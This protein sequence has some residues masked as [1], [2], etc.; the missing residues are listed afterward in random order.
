M[1]SNIAL[2]NKYD[3]SQNKLTYCQF[4]VALFAVIVYFSLLEHKDQELTQLSEGEGVAEIEVDFEQC[5]SHDPIAGHESS[6]SVLSKEGIM[7]L[8]GRCPVNENA[9]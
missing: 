1:N 4:L 2:S 3:Y 6:H 7:V 8:S 5:V 9:C